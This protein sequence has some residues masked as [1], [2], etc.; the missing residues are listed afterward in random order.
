MYSICLINR[1]MISEIILGTVV[2]FFLIYHSSTIRTTI[3][4][5]TQILH[6]TQE[7]YKDRPILQLLS[8]AIA[9]FELGKQSLYVAK[10]LFTYSQNSHITQLDGAI[11]IDY[12]LHGKPY[13]III[14]DKNKTEENIVLEAHGILD[15]EEKEDITEYISSIIGPDRDFHLQPIT[16]QLLG[17]DK[18]TIRYADSQLNEKEVVCLHSEII[19]LK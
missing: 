16:P 14:P 17:Y 19:Y 9:C 5:Y 10:G 2:P 3:D 11:S 8:P 15:E 13:T 6:T 4:I 18:V 12:T 7:T 1:K